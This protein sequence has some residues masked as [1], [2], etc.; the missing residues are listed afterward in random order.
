M[1]MGV[2]PTLLNARTGE[3]TPPGMEVWAREKR[4]VEVEVFIVVKGERSKSE[5]ERS[6]QKA[7]YGEAFVL[8]EMSLESILKVLFIELLIELQSKVPMKFNRFAISKAASIS[9]KDPR[10]ISK[11]LF[12]SAIDLREHPSARFKTTE[13]DARLICCTKLNRSSE[14]KLR[15]MA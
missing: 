15:V 13:M 9:T 4:E 6:I 10:D 3:F 8:T 5:S 2:P 12:R 11:N 14:G 7:N 1:K